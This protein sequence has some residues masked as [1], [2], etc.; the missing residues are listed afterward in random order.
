M[1]PPFR[2]GCCPFVVTDRARADAGPSF[3]LVILTPSLSSSPLLCLS[4]PCFR[5]PPGR[6]RHP[7]VQEGQGDGGV[8]EGAR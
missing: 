8:D 5:K 4:P 3:S 7:K 6:D 1:V 2:R